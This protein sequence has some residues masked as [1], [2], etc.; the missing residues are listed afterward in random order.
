MKVSEV[1]IFGYLW[2]NRSDCLGED[3][4]ILKPTE[5]EHDHEKIYKTAN[6]SYKGL[7]HLYI[8]IYIPNFN[9]WSPE[10][11]QWLKSYSLISWV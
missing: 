6:L 4:M 10:H 9:F 2:W 3:H 1:T 8:I 7:R 5:M 11:S